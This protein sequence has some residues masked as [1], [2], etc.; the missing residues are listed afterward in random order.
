MVHGYYMTT[1]DY[2]YNMYMY[3]MYLIVPMHL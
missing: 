1:H 3:Y 2:Y